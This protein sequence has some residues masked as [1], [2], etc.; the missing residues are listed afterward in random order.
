MSHPSH[1]EAWKRLDAIYPN[2]ASESRNVCLG[3]CID[4]FAPFGQSGKTYS[5]WPVIVTPYNLPLD[6]CM[7]TQYLFLSM[8]VPSLKNPKKKI[9]VCLQP[10]IDE[11]MQLWESGATT[12]DVSSNE[13]FVMH[14]ALLWTINDFPVMLCCPDGV[15][16]E[17]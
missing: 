13:N 16:L 6:M 17:F 15:R 1:G 12:Y 11:L 9:D 4:G 3:L 10:L 7:K 5:C 2:F 14:A 8:I